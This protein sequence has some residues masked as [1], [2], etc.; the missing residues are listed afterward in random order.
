MKKILEKKYTIEE[1]EKEATKFLEIKKNKN[2][3][4]YINYRSSFNYFIYYIKNIAEIKSISLKN[5]DIILD[6][7]QGALISGFKYNDKTVKLKASGINTHLRRIKTFFNKCL[8]LKA[9]VQTLKVSKAKYKSL[10]IEEIELL[11][12]ECSNK[13][14]NIEI[15]TRNETL[16]RFL[17]NTA[18]RINEALNIK[19]S[20]IYKDGNLYYVRIHEKGK[21]IGEYTEI[22][23]SEK[24]YNLLQHYINI[25][26][27]PSDYVFSSTKIS[28][29]GKAKKFS[30]ENFNK[31]IRE[32]ASYIDLKHDTNITKTILN[33]SSHVF[34][35]SK[36]TY[37]LNVVKEDVVTVQKILR[38]SSINSTL[39][40]LNP[41]EEAI[42]NVRINNDI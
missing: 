39:I 23:I 20:D 33:N 32:L 12:N 17:F 7:F 6:G 13:W 34:R 22:A 35:H 19:T 25:K 11:A 18:F 16:I 42:N 3:T 10:K 28:S 8:G 27:V 24:T 14:N 41:E 5:K 37:L 9:N 15:A 40:Y 2:N 30:R 1:I 26:T 21:A 36:A 31:A 29:N 38:H 4:T